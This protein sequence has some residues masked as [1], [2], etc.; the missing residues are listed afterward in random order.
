[1]PEPPELGSACGAALSWKSFTGAALRCTVMVHRDSSPPGDIYRVVVCVAVDQFVLRI[2]TS[3]GRHLINQDLEGLLL[4]RELLLLQ[5][6]H[7][8][9]IFLAGKK[10]NIDEVVHWHRSLHTVPVGL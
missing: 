8:L 4:C 5:I 3:A 7:L 9:V 1:L 6:E 2:N 10:T